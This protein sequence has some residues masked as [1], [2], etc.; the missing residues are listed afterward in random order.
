MTEEVTKMTEPKAKSKEER[1][2]QIRKEGMILA[3]VS[4]VLILLWG[5]LNNIDAIAW[6]QPFLLMGAIIFAI[7]GIIHMV[8][9]DLLRYGFRQ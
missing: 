1:E 8:M 3:V 4:V 7:L 2:R 9:M 5:W 6:L